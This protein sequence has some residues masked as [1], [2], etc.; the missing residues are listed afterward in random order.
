MKGGKLLEERLALGQSSVNVGSCDISRCLLSRRA[1][2]QISEEQ[3][4]ESSQSKK[5]VLIGEQR[6]E[7]CFNQ[8]GQGRPL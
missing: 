8:V 5:Q 7:A 1:A 2:R 3:S 6:Q 4:D